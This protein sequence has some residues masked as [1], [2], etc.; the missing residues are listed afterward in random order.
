MS[1]RILL[2]NPDEWNGLFTAQ[3]DW[4]VAKSCR[5]GIRL[6]DRA[7]IM[8]TNRKGNERGIF[9]AGIIVDPPFRSVTDGLSPPLFWSPHPAATPTASGAPETE[10]MSSHVN[11]L[12]DIPCDIHAS[13]DKWRC[14]EVHPVLVTW[15]KLA[16]TPPFNSFFG[17]GGRVNIPASGTEINKSGVVEPLREECWKAYQNLR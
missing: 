16:S 3:I 6:G 17:Y 11:V 12:V 7:F 15:A 8:R 10:E 9:A 2:H 1:G 4:H 13:P 14:D 5:S